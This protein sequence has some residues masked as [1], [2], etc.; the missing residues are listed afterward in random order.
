MTGYDSGLY[1]DG[2]WDDTSV[3][4]T[5]GWLSKKVEIAFGYTPADAL[6]LW[7]DVSSKV[8]SI[9]TNRGRDPSLGSFASGS[10]TIVL[11][12]QDG[13]F[14]PDNPSS[15]YVNQLLP[16][17]PVRISANDSSFTN[18]LIFTG[19]VVLRN[20][21]QQNYTS[22]VAATTTV[23]CV[24]Y[25][26]IL[27]TKKLAPFTTTATTFDLPILKAAQQYVRFIAGAGPLPTIPTAA[28]VGYTTGAML[29][30]LVLAG[31]IPGPGTGGWSVDTTKMI[32][33]GYLG[34]DN[35]LTFV[36]NLAAV[37]A[38]AVWVT[39]DGIVRFDGRYS[40]FTNDRQ[41]SFQATFDS[42]GGQTPFSINGFSKTDA[43]EIYNSVTVTPDN[44]PPQT[45]IDQPSIDQYT[46]SSPSTMTGPYNTAWDAI[47]QA[48]M[49]IANYKDRISA[50]RTLTIFPR[51]SDGTGSDPSLDT[52]LALDLRDAV[53]VNWTPPIEA[54]AVATTS[55]FSCYVERIQHHLSVDGNWSVDYEFSA[56]RPL[57]GDRGYITYDDGVSVYD[58]PS[59]FYIY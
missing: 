32:T 5:S 37:E 45:V 33:Q 6:P 52:A 58:D 20:G 10:A 39:S 19:Y 51:R 41:A 17:V 38:G 54:P 13:A 46:E 18:R 29:T 43:D 53:A 15:P 12:N 26:A 47:A 22:G 8:R 55:N 49:V 34:A 23:Q 50:P 30:A 25:L 11:K 27:A 44:Q 21:W 28:Y 56:P 40:T 1:D 24:D 4:S 35:A 16:M 14:D 9:D 42:A 36:K 57:S 48:Q 7:T 59:N 3:T 31:T 2:V